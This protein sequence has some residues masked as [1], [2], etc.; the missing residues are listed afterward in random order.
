[1]FF[2]FCLWW[3]YKSTKMNVNE[4]NDWVYLCHLTLAWTV[5]LRTLVK[6]RFFPCRLSPLTT[7]RQVEVCTGTV[8]ALPASE[9]QNKHLFFLDFSDSAA[10]LSA[11][12]LPGAY[13][14][15]W[16]IRCY[17]KGRFTQIT[18]EKNDFYSI[19]GYLSLY[20][21][22]YYITRHLLSHTTHVS[23]HY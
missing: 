14:L 4:T 2:M 8:F 23:V 19:R 3:S 17:L 21:S 7:S 18:K 10:S 1:M 16:F 5:S 20:Y 6:R 11:C 13:G 22:H 15:W 12:A 9:W